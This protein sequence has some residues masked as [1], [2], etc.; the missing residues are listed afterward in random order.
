MTVEL[1]VSQ[2]PSP[3][4]RL[5]E[6][7]LQLPEVCTEIDCLLTTYFS[8]NAKSTQNPMYLW[9][10]HKCVVWGVLIRF[11]TEEGKGGVE[12]LALSQDHTMLGLDQT[13]LI[14]KLQ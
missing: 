5:N 7:L 11:L 1:K 13:V 9:E 10:A 6:S 12:R 14:R 4:W 3:T 2:P 8:E